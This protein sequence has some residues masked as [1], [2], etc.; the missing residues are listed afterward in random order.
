MA[1]C[2]PQIEWYNITVLIKSFC[3]H[4]M[5]LFSSLFALV[6]LLVSLCRLACIVLTLQYWSVR[7]RKAVCFWQMQVIKVPSIIFIC[8]FHSF[9]YGK[10][11]FVVCGTSLWDHIPLCVNYRLTS[12]GRLIDFCLCGLLKRGSCPLVWLS[13]A[14]A[15]CSASFALSI[16]GECRRWGNLR[17]AGVLPVSWVQ[18]ALRW[19]DSNW[20][21]FIWSFLSGA[22]QMEKG[23][24]GEE[25]GEER[26]AKVKKS[27]LEPHKDVKLLQRVFFIREFWMLLG[28]SPLFHPLMGIWECISSCVKYLL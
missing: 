26:K 9:I 28:H 24:G 3:I 27:R 21:F 12:A 11:G 25:V 16:L 17:L 2:T 18:T 6:F 14:Q 5:L 15:Q 23:E 10:H 13:G 22:L 19:N 8:S 7:D 20:S 1:Q 4:D